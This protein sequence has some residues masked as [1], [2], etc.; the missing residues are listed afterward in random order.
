MINATLQSIFSDSKNMK[1]VSVVTR[2]DVTPSE[3]METLAK[4]IF[5]EIQRLV[6]YSEYPGTAE[7]EPTDILKYLKT[8]VWLRV[9]HVNQNFGEV[10]APYKRL[11]RTLEVPVLPYQLL[12]A[13]GETYDHDY[14]IRFVPEY[15]IES[16]DLLSPSEMRALSEVMLTLRVIGFAS[17]T[18]LPRDPEGDLAFMALSHVENFVSGYRNDHP[19][20]GFLASFFRQQ[21][22]NEVTGTMCRII[23]GYDSDYD[24]M[25][26][27]IMAKLSAS[28][29]EGLS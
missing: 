8:L 13:I 21:E 19:V 16:A 14:A 9:C 4:G 1:Q 26:R 28:Q 22:L 18:G 10:G 6:P 29:P 25:I 2:V 24:V 7:L 27:S 23:Y 17:V 5:A 11:M 15:S 20:Y 12:I 3:L